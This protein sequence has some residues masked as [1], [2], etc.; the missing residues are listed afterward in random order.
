MQSKK[1][2]VDEA[3]SKSMRG[4]FGA[5]VEPSI[6]APQG[7][8]SNSVTSLWEMMTIPVVDE[9]LNSQASENVIFCEEKIVTEL[10]DMR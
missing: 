1:D 8:W 10:A 3:F 9:V 2:R 7:D 6:R 5:L 4:F